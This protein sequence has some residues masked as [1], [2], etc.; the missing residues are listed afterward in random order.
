MKS[1]HQNFVKIDMNYVQNDRQMYYGT[2]CRFGT[3]YGGKNN[4]KID[5]G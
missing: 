2:V 3:A 1:N 5:R 4:N